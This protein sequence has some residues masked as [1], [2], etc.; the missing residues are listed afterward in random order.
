MQ[1]KSK[2]GQVEVINETGTHVFGVEPVEIDAKIG[3][4]LVANYPDLTEVVSDIADA[5]LDVDVDTDETP[6]ITDKPITALINK[7]RK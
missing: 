1:V 5:V 4:S 7:V 3:A 6:S 2:R